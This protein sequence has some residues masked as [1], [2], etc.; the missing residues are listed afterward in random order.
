[1]SIILWCGVK[2]CSMLF[3][4]LHAISCCGMLYAIPNCPVVSCFVMRSAAT[5]RFQLFA[6]IAECLPVLLWHA[7]VCHLLLLSAARGYQVPSY[8]AAGVNI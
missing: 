5:S 8:V 4:L 1:M 2:C 3:V 6:R 7:L